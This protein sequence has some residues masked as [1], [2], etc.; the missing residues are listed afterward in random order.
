MRFHLDRE[1][2][3]RRRR[4][5]IEFGG[6]LLHRRSSEECLIHA[7]GLGRC[8]EKQRPSDEPDEDNKGVRFKR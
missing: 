8:R 7:L 1:E 5:D 4:R 3:L 2:G 6:T